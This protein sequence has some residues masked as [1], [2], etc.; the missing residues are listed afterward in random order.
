MTSTSSSRPDRRHHRL[1]SKPSTNLEPIELEI[2][3]INRAS[4]KTLRAEWS[5]LI[6]SPPADHLSKNIIRGIVAY[7]LQENAFGG[8]DRAA[9]RF[10]DRLARGRKAR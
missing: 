3:R 7:R 9:Q 4:L 5:K 10:L 1:R 8:F 6:G 2:L